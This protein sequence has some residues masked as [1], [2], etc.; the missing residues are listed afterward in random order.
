M[1]SSRF[2]LLWISL[3]AL[4]VSC[5]KEAFDAYYGR[6]DWLAS[7]IYQQL[8]SMGDFKNFLNC[9]QLSGYQNTLG[10]AGSWT[11]FAPTDKAFE[12]FMNEQGIADMTKVSPELAE[13]IVRSSM[14]YDGERIEKLS[15]FFSKQ[16]WQPGLAF[17][18]RSVY[19][20]FV[21]SEDLGNGKIRKFV[22]TNRGSDK[23][24][25]P[26]ENNN[27]HLT[28]FFDAYMAQR[29]LGKSDYTVF[30][31]N[32]TYSGLNVGAANI[33][34]KRN[35][36]A[37]ENGYIHVVDRVLLPEKSI[38]QYL[39]R[40]DEYSSF[41]SI[42]DLFATY[43]YNAD[44]TRKNEVL[45]GSKDSVFVKSY[46]GVGLALNN[47]NYTKEDANDA[48]INNFSVT[49]PSNE[50]VDKYVRGMLL[51]YYPKGS[52]LKDLYATNSGVLVE[53]INSHLYNT[54]L[55]PSQFTNQQNFL[56]E[57]TKLTK[58][59]IK[60]TKLLSNGTFYG[61][62]VCQKANVFQSVYGSVLLN[63]KYS[64]MR[65]AIERM[66]MNLTLKIPTLRYMLVLVSDD[67]LY[68]MGFDYDAY[69][70]TD[71]I[72]YKGGNGTPEMRE[73]LNAHIIPLNNDPIPD[74]SGTGVLESYAGEYI[75]YD[76]MMLSSSGTLDSVANKQA[77]KI[78]STSTG[79]NLSGPLNGVSVYLDGGLTSSNTNIG[80]F[81]QKMGADQVSSPYNA[82]YNYLIKSTLYSAT[83]GVVKGIELGLNYS[84]L[85][86]N[87][88]AIAAAIAEGDL[89]S[90]NAPTSQV[91]IDKVTRF[92][93]YH[94]TRN[95]FAIDGKKTGYF[96]TL[97][98]N[99]DGDAQSVQVVLNQKNKLQVMDNA[100]RVVDANIAQS[101]LLGQRVVIHSISSYLKHGL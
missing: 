100:G 32:S 20:D 72:R 43:T 89:P 62:D 41:K 73:V 42:L 3:L 88:A 27:K 81:L 83:D 86:P 12:Q 53:F 54:Q 67:N 15:D 49:I 84:M 40:S 61:V 26:I 95:S 51:Q 28:Y 1:L 71:P 60:E 55:W 37:A 16:G 14:T 22:S 46:T 44:L 85:I 9:I 11:V 45:T 96:Q 92:I 75:K 82:F 7:P 56:G 50:A 8:D 80:F 36:I 30:Y 29:G 17:R 24:Y 101:N 4:T 87:N 23:L 98:K 2:T 25:V 35:N 68:K 21:E 65:R 90:A 13:R 48:Q 34:P 99:I 6:P 39:T 57:S 18:R 79:T 76:H 59:N 94:I 38:D 31:P 19:Y 47:E 78:D 64:L 52:T 77:L 70:T 69:N 93:Q 74:L 10:T 58:A 63:P 5:R 97:C 91:D 66:G 33:D